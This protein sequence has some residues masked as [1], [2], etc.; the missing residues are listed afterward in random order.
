M[1]EFAFL[2]LEVV[3]E[4]PKGKVASYGQIAKISGYPKNAR[5]VGKVLSNAEFYGTYPC[6]R[7]LHSDGSLVLGWDEQKDLLSTEG[8]VLLKNGKVDMKKYK[9][10]V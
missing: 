7:V 1:D 4:I 2:I 5:K 3:N 8:V 6:H 10:E 9:W